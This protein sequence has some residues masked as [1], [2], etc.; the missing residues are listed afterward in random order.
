VNDIADGIQ[1]A[2]D[3]IETT[4]WSLEQQEDWSGALSAY[5]RGTAML[6]AL[7]VPPG[8]AE[9]GHYNK[10]LAYSLM[11]QANAL[12]VLKRPDEANALADRELAAARASG[13]G[14]TMG[15][16]LISYG[17][18]CVTSGDVPRGI[19]LLD[20]ARA[21]FAS[22]DSKDHRQGLGW[23]WII[24]ADIANAGMLD[25]PP[26]DVITWATTAL[27]IL[28]PLENWPGIARSH[29]AR[30]KAYDTLGDHDAASADREAQARYEALARESGA[31]YDD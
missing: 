6:D 2:E 12:R 8:H 19:A 16:T 24:Q 1:Q 25:A 13:D 10:V 26:H 5:Q 4:L 17:I 11:R 27:D 29:A 30:A 28:T 9:Y 20:E 22:G 14:I 23:A 3:L 21:A 7:M 18:K 31:V 15:Q